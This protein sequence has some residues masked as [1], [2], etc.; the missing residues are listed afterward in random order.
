MTTIS[1][2][3]A[4]PAPID[5]VWEVVGDWTGISK[6]H[7]FVEKSEL[8]EGPPADTAGATRVCTLADGAALKETQV[9]RSDQNFMY[10]YSITDAPMPIRNHK[11]VVQLRPITDTNQTFAEWTTEFEADGNVVEMIKGMFEAAIP[12]GLSALKSHFS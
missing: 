10:A 1:A 4:I 8:G 11:G 3:A 6:W 9:E 2:T 12:A 7:P 5:Q